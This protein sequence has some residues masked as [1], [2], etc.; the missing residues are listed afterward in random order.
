MLSKRSVLVFGLLLLTSSFTNCA[1]QKAGHHQ[2][3]DPMP[4]IEEVQEAYTD[5]WM[6]IP[7]VVGTGIGESKGKPC[8]RVFVARKT[9]EL[10]KKLPSQ[11]EGFPVIIEETGEF[12]A[13]G[14]D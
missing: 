6:A 13:L 9:E 1:G 2:R 11:V 8:I 4:T 3:V 12:R 10:E 7:G 14:V 5:A